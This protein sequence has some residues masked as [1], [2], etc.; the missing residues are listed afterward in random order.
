MIA[1]IK[2]WNLSL[3]DIATIIT[4]ITIIIGGINYYTE[5]KVN[6]ALNE[7]RMT[8]NEKDIHD[9]EFVLGMTCR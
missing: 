2:T 3:N 6:Q 8:N 4:I 5:Y 9:I 1:K 7:Q